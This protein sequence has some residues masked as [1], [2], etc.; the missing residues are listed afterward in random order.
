MEY[1][2]SKMHMYN[3]H[4]KSTRV[5]IRHKLYTVRLQ[6]DAHGA[7][8]YVQVQ[9]LRHYLAELTVRDYGTHY[10]T[11][12]DAGAVLSQTDFIRTTDTTDKTQQV[13]LRPVLTSLAKCLLVLL[14]SML[15]SVTIQKSISAAVP[16]PRLSQLGVCHSSPT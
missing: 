12:M 5:Q 9:A 16:I 14:S 10:L 3:D 6:P 4:A 11:S 2:T 1:S 8:S 13:K 7:A 15:R